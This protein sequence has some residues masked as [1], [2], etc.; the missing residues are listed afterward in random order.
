MTLAAFIARWLGF[1]CVV[2]PGG[3]GPQCVDLVN[4]WALVR[5]RPR[6]AGNAAQLLALA[7]PALWLR[8]ANT[9][10]NVTPAGALSASQAD[11]TPLIPA[12]GVGARVSISR[13]AKGEKLSDIAQECVRHGGFLERAAGPCRPPL[14]THVCKR[15]GRPPSAFRLLPRP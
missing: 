10:T 4:A 15:G 9:P 6:L 7:P 8:T 1:A 11:Q 12:R 3:L 2:D 5:G 14:L 13:P